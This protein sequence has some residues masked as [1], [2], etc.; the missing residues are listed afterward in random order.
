MS[1]NNILDL[2]ISWDELENQ[3]RKFRDDHHIEIV[4]LGPIHTGACNPDYLTRA[5]DITI[6]KLP[7]SITID[8]SGF[9]MAGHTWATTLGKHVAAAYLV[10]PYVLGEALD[11]VFQ[12]YH[13]AMRELLQPKFEG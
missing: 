3:A 2:D 13:D 12:P 7:Y 4:L 8:N 5:I 6:D 10:S 11:F 9:N 1:T